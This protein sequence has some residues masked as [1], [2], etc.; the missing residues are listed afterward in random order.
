LAKSNYSIG[1]I[2]KIASSIDRSPDLAQALNSLVHGIHAALN[3][4]VCSVY[5]ADTANHTNILMASYGLNPDAVGKVVIP[6]EEGLVGLVTQLSKPVNISDAQSHPRFKY[7]PEC[8]EEPFKSFL[9]VPITLHGEQL[10][11]L[12]IQQTS[13][14]KFGDRDQAFLST[15]AA[16]IAGNIAL[17]R[18]RGQIK[19]ILSLDKMSGGRFTGIAGAPGVCIGTGVVT[20]HPNDILEVPNRQ[21]RNTFLEEERLRAAITEVILESKH[22]G[23]QM[24]GAVPETDKIIFEAYALLAGSEELINETIRRIRDGNWAPGALRET[25]AAY[26]ARFESLDDPYMRERAND[27]RHIGQRILANLLHEEKQQYVYPEKTVLIGENLSPLDLADV[28]LEKLAGIVTGHGSAYSH[29]AILAR[30]LGIPAV[31]GLA[32][33]IPVNRLDAKALIVD[34]YQGSIAVSPDEDLLGEYSALMRKEA[35]LAEKVSLLRDQPAVTTDGVRIRLYTNTGL[36]AGHTHAIEVGTEGIGLYR[37]EFPFM[38]RDNFPT[39]EEQQLIYRQVIATYAPR[40]V[41]LRTLDAGGDKVLPYLAYPEPNPFLGWRGIRVVL[42]HPEILLTQVRA[43]L[44]ASEGYDNVQILIPMIS[45]IEELERTIS[46]IRQVYQS[47]REDGYAVKFPPVGIMIEVPATLFQL[48]AILERVDFLS[49]GTNDLVQYLLAIDRNN[50]RVAKYFDHL[51]PAVLRVL[52]QIIS[53]AKAHGKPVSICGEAAGDPELVI[54]LIAMGVDSLS[55]SALALPRIKWVIRSFSHARACELWTQIQ[56][57]EHVAGIRELLHL[58]LVQHGL[59][60][61]LRTGSPARQLLPAA[62]A[63]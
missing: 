17:A 42:D 39:G 43:M 27:I 58:E 31:L 28:P 11:V 57:L 55:L 45:T 2:Q 7:I 59:G 1:T 9:G 33:Q 29:M 32:Q 41:T 8:G 26:A 54:P 44:L 20:Y 38:N 35:E 19:E 48:D 51:H 25:I 40:P 63:A 22:V 10:A 18:A 47:V 36:L 46:L 5:L 60:E 23:E 30:A 61:L 34:G 62:T 49:I 53:A 37:S 52:A 13:T 16:M 14:R 4:D 56:R 15:L 50:E 3:V 12:V 24:G 21:A 6:F